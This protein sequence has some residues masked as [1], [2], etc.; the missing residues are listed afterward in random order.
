MTLSITPQIL[1][2][3]ARLSECLSWVS[4]KK[5]KISAYILIWATE[6][7]RVGWGVIIDM[8]VKILMQCLKAV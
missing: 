6:T 4:K 3:T 5:K 7:V 1:S 8:R 2:L